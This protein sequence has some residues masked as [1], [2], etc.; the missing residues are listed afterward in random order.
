MRVMFVNKNI[1]HTFLW[2]R[3]IGTRDKLDNATYI[4]VTWFVSLA[5]RYEDE[6]IEKKDM[7]AILRAYEKKRDMRTVF[8]VEI[9][10]KT[11]T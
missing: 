10:K 2:L 9:L 11:T 1:E 7:G 6:R 5:K 8:S 3:I 4:F